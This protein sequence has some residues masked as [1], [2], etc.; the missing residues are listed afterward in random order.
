MGGTLGGKFGQLELVLIFDRSM[1][2]EYHWWQ[3]AGN[4]LGWAGVVLK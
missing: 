2:W 3:L 1:T 4:K